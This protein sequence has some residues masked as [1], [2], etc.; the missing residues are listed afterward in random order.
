MITKEKFILLTFFLISTIFVGSLSNGSQAYAGVGTIPLAVGDLSVDEDVGNASVVVTWDPL[1]SELIGLTDV[2][3]D[4]ATSDGTALAGSDYTATSTQVTV[5][6]VGGLT[7]INIPITDDMDIESAEDFTVTLTDPNAGD[8]TIDD[9]IVTI[10]NNDLLP[11][12]VENISVDEN[13]GNAQVTVIWSEAF[14]PVYID[15]LAAQFGMT[16]DYAT[17]DGTANTGSDYTATS[18]S[19]S[20]FDTAPFVINIPIT[21]DSDPEADEFFTVTLTDPNAGD[22]TIDDATVTINAN[23]A[24]EFTC[25]EG[26]VENGSHC[27]VDPA[28]TQQISDL[29]SDLAICSVELIDTQDDL[30]S[31]QVDLAMCMEESNPYTL[32]RCNDIKDQYNQKIADGKNISKKLQSDYDTCIELYP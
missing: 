20:E 15:E 27:V 26:T 17:S 19:V 8:T 16:F 31:C 5:P 6:N 13:V 21:D 2:T 25:G 24:A 3:F 23:D 29:Q 30:N 4:Y 18:S 10:N 32:T 22:A 11:L 1:A 28:L 9:A 14:D 7:L 12:V